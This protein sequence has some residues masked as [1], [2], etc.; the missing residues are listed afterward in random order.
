MCGVEVCVVWRCVWC[1][2]VCGVEMF[3]V[4]RYMC[5]GGVCGIGVSG[6]YVVQ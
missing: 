5:C 4:W 2:G 1:G 3:V 6:V